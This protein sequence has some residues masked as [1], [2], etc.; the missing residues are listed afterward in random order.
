MYEIDLNRID[1]KFVYF[2]SFSISRPLSSVCGSVNASPVE[3]I[4]LNM[5]VFFSFLYLISFLFGLF[6]FIFIAHCICSLKV[7][8]RAALSVRRPACAFC[9]ANEPCFVMHQFP[10]PCYRWVIYI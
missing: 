8:T 5:Y 3:F 4:H 1:T 7:V 9:F 6:F 10:M 2:S